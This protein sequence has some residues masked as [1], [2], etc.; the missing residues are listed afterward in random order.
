MLTIQNRNAQNFGIISIIQWSI[1]LNLSLS[2]WKGEI[3]TVTAYI[4]LLAPLD[5]VILWCT[6]V[7]WNLLQITYTNIILQV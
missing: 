5:A 6:M 1:P 4:S 3:G 2:H 7:Y